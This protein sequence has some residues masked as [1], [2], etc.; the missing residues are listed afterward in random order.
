[1]T[2]VSLNACEWRKEELWRNES[3]REAR[4]QRRR[5]ATD[6][7]AS[8]NDHEL[9]LQPG[10]GFIL[11]GGFALSFALL[12]AGCSCS[13]RRPTIEAVAI[14]KIQLMAMRDVWWLPCYVQAI[15]EVLESWGSYFDR[16][17]LHSLKIMIFFENYGTNVRIHKWIGIY[18][19]H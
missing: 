19:S 7:T 2:S 17:L 12:G 5:V 18:L 8:G 9:Q 16:R 3:E 15:G 14:V 13:C 4:W 1:M 6:S 10:S 11:W